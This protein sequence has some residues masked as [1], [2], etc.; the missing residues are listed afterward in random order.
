MKLN[1]FVKPN[2]DER[3]RMLRRENGLMKLN[4]FVKPNDQSKLAHKEAFAFLR[5]H[6]SQNVVAKKLTF[7]LSQKR[8]RIGLIERII[9]KIREIRGQNIRTI[10]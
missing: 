1:V 5:M 6:I 8:T 2:A 4:V 7:S 9:R 3:A 10:L